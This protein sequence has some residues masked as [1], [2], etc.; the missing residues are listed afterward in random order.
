[1]MEE[2]GLNVDAMATMCCTGRRFKWLASELYRTTVGLGY[3]TSGELLI[4]G[5]WL[6]R[7]KDRK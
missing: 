7:V 2:V 4:R 1:M 3:G 5:K 6:H